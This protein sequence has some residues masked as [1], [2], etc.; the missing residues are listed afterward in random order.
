MFVGKA[1][2]YPREKH[3]FLN[4]RV[5]S[6]PS[7]QTKQGWAGKACSSLLWKVVTYARKMFYNIGPRPERFARDKR[8]SLF[9]LVISDE[10]NKVY[11][12]DVSKQGSL[13]ANALWKIEHQQL[14]KQNITGSIWT[15]IFY[16]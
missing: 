3:Q 12:N 13:G 14:L 4:F 1:G 2:A 15:L 8:S 5:G 10:E 9:R 6:W 7:P 11:D 16:N